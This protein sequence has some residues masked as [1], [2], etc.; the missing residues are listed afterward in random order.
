VSL[1]LSRFA[2]RSRAFVQIQ[3]GCDAFCTYCIIPHA[4]G[5]SRSLP[6]AQALAQVRE[7][8]A[9]GYPEIVL[10]GIHI[11]GYGADLSPADLPA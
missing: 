2:G 11:G 4:R 3:N 9:A 6:P 10:T 1:G 7:L 8:V 5:R